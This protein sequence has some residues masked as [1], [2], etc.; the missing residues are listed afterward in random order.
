LKHYDHNLGAFH[1]RIKF[2]GFLVKR[3][4]INTYYSNPEIKIWLQRW[5]YETLQK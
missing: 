1:N 2:E 5:N 4:K 3:A